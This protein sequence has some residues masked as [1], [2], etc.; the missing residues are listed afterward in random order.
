MAWHWSERQEKTFRSIK[1]KLTSDAILQYYDVKKSTTLL[2]DASSY[3][4]GACLLQEGR[5]V[6][7]APRSLSSAERN[8]TQIEKELLAIVYG[9]TKFHQY[10]YRKKIR[11]QTDHKPLEALFRKPLFQAPQRLQRIMLRLQCYDLQVEYEPGKNLYIADTLSRAPEGQNETA[12][13][14]K[15][16]FEVL[17]IENITQIM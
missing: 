13:N 6:C 1:G 7:Y 17:I 10:V 9:C 2:V 14:S 3:G 4:L 15:D 5:P 8:Y 11:V 16:E 12:A